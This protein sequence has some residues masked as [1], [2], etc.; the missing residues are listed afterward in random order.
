MLVC[1]RILRLKLTSIS[2]KSYFQFASVG[3]S[4]DVLD[5]KNSHLLYVNDPKA[6]LPYMS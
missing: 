3:G 5:I 6:S 2:Q 4:F 1:C